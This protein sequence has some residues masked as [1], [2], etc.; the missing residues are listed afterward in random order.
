MRIV[1]KFVLILILPN[2]IFMIPVELLIEKG[3]TIKK[4]NA[5]E[6]IYRENS[7]SNYYYQLES[8]R[9]RISNFLEDGKEVLHKM[10]CANEGFG[11]VAILDEG[12]HVVTAIAD[13]SCSILKISSAA[14]M[15]ILTE[16]SSIQLM[17]TKQIAKDLRFKHFITKLI[18]NHSPE[19]IIS[20]L[21]QRLNEDRRL[22]CPQ[23]KRLMLTRQ[24]LANMT[25]LRVETIIRTMKL[26]EKEEKLNIV[27]GKVIVC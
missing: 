19:E 27:R 7:P 1:D 2:K 26:M 12:M 24:Q 8:G 22:I 15:E 14:F 4:W 6:I 16:Y 18:F 23:C 10:V 13:N 9:V 21:L 17:I 3:A 5:G 25:G 20:G 11:E